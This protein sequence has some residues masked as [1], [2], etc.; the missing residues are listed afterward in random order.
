M[1]ETL[2]R[3]TTVMPS[4]GLQLVFDEE[5]IAIA[6][7]VTKNM[8]QQKVFVALKDVQ[9]TTGNNVTPTGVVILLVNGSELSGTATGV[10]PVDAISKAI[11]QALGNSFELK[12]YSLKAITGG[13]DALGDVSVKIIDE[14]GREFSG[15]AL[16]EDITLAS[17]EALIKCI[18]KSMEEK[19]G[20][21]SR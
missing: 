13:T 18:N 12:E 16:N 8:E 10:G 15:Q 5:I 4:S 1:Q 19:S 9:V 3:L 7:T 6:S 20:S 2:K 14:R 17:A 11:K 21:G